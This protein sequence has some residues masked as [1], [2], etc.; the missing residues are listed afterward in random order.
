MKLLRLGISD[1]G[2]AG[3]ENVRKGME[4]GEKVLT[5]LGF[6]VEAIKQEINATYI[7]LII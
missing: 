2:E 4:R 7:Q 1:I 3:I 5:A 6:N